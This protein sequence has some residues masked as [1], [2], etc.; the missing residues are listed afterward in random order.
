MGKLILI[1]LALFAL[2]FIVSSII[3]FIV[4]ISEVKKQQEEYRD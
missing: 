1:F 4:A 2:C 3:G